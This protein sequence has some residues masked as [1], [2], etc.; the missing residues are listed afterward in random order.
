ML[1]SGHYADE[2]R[3][4]EEKWQR[5]GI[6]GVPAVVVNDRYLITGARA[7]GGVRA[8]HPEGRVRSRL[9]VRR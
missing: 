2:V 7:A 1:T 4:A 6:S 8:G 3:E 5:A 9:T